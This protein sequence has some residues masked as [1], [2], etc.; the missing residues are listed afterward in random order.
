MFIMKS[1]NDQEECVEVAVI[2]EDG[3]EA[4]VDSTMVIN[5]LKENGIQTLGKKMG[6][7]NTQSVESVLEKNQF[8]VDVD[9]YSTNNGM[10]VGTAKLCIRVRQKIPIMLVFDNKSAYYVDSQAEIIKADTMYARNVLVAN[11]DIN[12]N[13]LPELVELAQFIHQDEFWDNQIEQIYVSKE[14]L[15]ERHFQDWME[16][17]FGTQ[18]RIRQSGGGNYQ[19]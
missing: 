5:I 3:P 8:I 15:S 11:G 6:D 18:P 12:Q 2:M 9:C 7:I 4:F 16:Q 14:V 13:Y 17:I 1:T 19:G 10:D